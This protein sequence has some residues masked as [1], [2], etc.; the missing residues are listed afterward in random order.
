MAAT[1]VSIKIVISPE[2]KG[3]KE[4]LLK[5]LE[6]GKVTQEQAIEKLEARVKEN[7]EFE[8]NLE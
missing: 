8:V 3:Y 7:I 5:E 2:F 6:D 4:A 1:E